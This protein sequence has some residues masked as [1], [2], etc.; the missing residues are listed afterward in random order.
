[1]NLTDK[2]PVLAAKYLTNQTPVYARALLDELNNEE[3]SD[4]YYQM[5][6]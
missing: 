5:V 4:L 1:M 6:A 3:V 2:H